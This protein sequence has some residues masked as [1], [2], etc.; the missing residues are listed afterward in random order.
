M[1][2]DTAA[3]TY[4]AET[5]RAY[6]E[7]QAEITGATA[8]A[9]ARWHRKIRRAAR[10][11]E[12]ATA[13]T[14]GGTMN[15]TARTARSLAMTASCAALAGAALTAAAV[16]ASASAHVGRCR[17]GQVAIVLTHPVQ[18]GGS[19]G[20]TV[21][22]QDK[23]NTACTISGY[24][25]LGLQGR[26]G[27]RLRS[28]VEDGTT[29]FH[30]DPGASVVVL[31]PAGFAQAWLAYGTV[32]GPGSVNAHALTIRIQGAASHKTAILA[33]GTVTVTRAVV[34]VTA[35]KLRKG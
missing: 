3:C 13:I 28:T 25:R 26:H 8:G 35:W 4:L 2:A 17:N 5:A 33:S 30:G 18:Q 10:R 27:Q 31:Q 23:G 24:P 29:P 22:A 32:S 11:Y 19:Q 14:N 12:R 15:I 7:Y 20:W 34:D 6:A 1:T 21:E 9:G 16:P